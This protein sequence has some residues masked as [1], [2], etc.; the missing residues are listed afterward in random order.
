LHA[1]EQAIVRVCV[2]SGAIAIFLA[3]AFL[4]KLVT[5]TAFT[6]D[7][8]WFYRDRTRPEGVRDRKALAD[9]W[10]QA[11]RSEDELM[12]ERDLYSIDEARERLGGISRN[13][14]YEILRS[15][16]LSSV[17]LGSR[18]LIP[19]AAI[20]ELIAQSAT[21]ISPT[22]AAA[23]S[24]IPTKQPIDISKRRPSQGQ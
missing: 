11:R 3:Q 12:K 23:R 20:A 19:A 7:R 24:Y 1:S 6:C 21:T 22:E 18:R 4:L 13:L 8:R 15:G 10:R 9:G 16:R 5:N 17:L 14:I 2:A